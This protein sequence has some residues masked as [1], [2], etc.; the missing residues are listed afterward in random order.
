[1]RVVMEAITIHKHL[2]PP[3]CFVFFVQLGLTAGTVLCWVMGS[4]L[5][6]LTQT[7]NM[8]ICVLGEYAIGMRR[9]MLSKQGAGCLTAQHIVPENGGNWEMCIRKD[10][11]VLDAAPIT[12]TL[13]VHTRG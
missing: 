6:L 8:H 1:M 10:R 7:T 9:K 12:L 4:L 3:L 11:Q 2:I 5:N 13:V